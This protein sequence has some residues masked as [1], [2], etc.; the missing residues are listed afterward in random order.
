MDKNICMDRTRGTDDDMKNHIFVFL[1]NYCVNFFFPDMRQYFVVNPQKDDLK[2]K[3][4]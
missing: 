2:E 1:S 3:C 4:L